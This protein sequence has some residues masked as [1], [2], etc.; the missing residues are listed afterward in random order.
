MKADD[1]RPPDDDLQRALRGGADAA[2]QLAELTDEI[3]RLRRAVEATTD[4]VTFHTR[5]GRVLFA[6]GAARAAIGLAV[7]EPFPEV[8]IHDFFAATPEQVAEIR[9][10][11]AD[12]GRWSGELDVNGVDRT[13]AASVVIIGHRD[14]EGRYEYF[15]ALSR[16]ITERR[17][18]DAARRRS[19]GALRAIVQ[20][21]PLAI[22]AVDVEG[23][24][25]VWNHA[26]EEL[27]GWTAAESI[28]AAPP[29]AE[30]ADELRELIARVFEGETVKSHEARCAARN[31][32]DLDVNI[33][34]APLR[35][36][37]GRVVSAVVVVADVT[38]QRR[39]ELALREREVRFRSLVQN[40]S[41]MVTILSSDNRVTYRSPSAWRFL[42]LDPEDDPEA[43][44][45]FGLFEEDRPAV[46]AM[47]ERLQAKPG[48]SETLLYRFQ[49]AA[50]DRDGC[51]RPQ[52][53]S[54]RRRRR[55]QRARHHRPNR[56]GAPHPCVRGTAAG[57]HLEHLRRH[58]GDRRR[59]QPALREP[60]LGPGLWLPRRR[61]AEQ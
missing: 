14:A 61:V 41:D 44:G 34:L 54:R 39:A 19:E 1:V 48:S 6:N 20:A 12:Y 5:T 53:R 23:A 22:L 35:N 57:T 58:L 28:G 13:I 43:P 25:Q 4:F 18:V 17:A 49:R 9:D 59:W 10:A 55:H 24:V 26:C 36:A 16:D 40:S 32:T 21:S 47:F 52:R 51:H 15:S 8:G 46:A 50:L 56:G 3:V 29:F 33:A 38:D 31:G 2:A 37:A 30:S 45:D 7:G 27:F 11:L 42:G 60:E